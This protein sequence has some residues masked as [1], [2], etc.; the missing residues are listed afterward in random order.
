M[1]TIH[2]IALAALLLLLA[3]DCA[4][5]ND[6]KVLSPFRRV[7]VSSHI[8]LVLQQGE[9][10]GIRFELENVSPDD[11]NVEVRGKTLHIFLD[12]ARTLD[13]MRRRNG[14]NY[15][16]AYKDVAIT[17]YVTYTRLDK[18]E[19]RGSQHVTCLSPIDTDK[20]FKLK[21]YGENTIELSSVR[22]DYLKTVLY[23]ENKVTIGGGRTTYQ[24]Y[25]LYGENK[26]DASK[27]KTHAASATAFGQ[28]DLKVFTHDELH[29]TAFGET[30]VAYGGDAFLSKGIIIGKTDIYRAN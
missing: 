11:I 1:K 23:G 7:V 28:S 3:P 26:I 17:A 29:V 2:L 19:V 6:S 5:I 25:K 18:I 15:E 22:T 21:A 20:K 12:D 16:S 13:K 30:R 4:A 8:N 9:T 10:E 24:R 27:V 14:R